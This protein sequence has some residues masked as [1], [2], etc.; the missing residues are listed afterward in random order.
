MQPPQK[1]AKCRTSKSLPKV[2][3][4]IDTHTI[5]KE[6][7]KQCLNI[8]P[9]LVASPNAQGQLE[10]TKNMLCLGGKK[11]ARAKT[12]R[13]KEVDN[14]IGVGEPVDELARILND[15]GSEAGE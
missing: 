13:E 1:P 10:P 9:V 15:G 2:G 6:Y 3:L 11:V 12:P 7:E 14:I 4:T 5:N 8:R